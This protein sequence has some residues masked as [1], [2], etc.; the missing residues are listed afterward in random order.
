[1]IILSFYLYWSHVPDG[2]SNHERIT[3][4][5]V[6]GKNK[7]TY[8]KRRN[9]MIKPESWIGAPGTEAP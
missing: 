5:V 2:H 9:N 8:L 1:M 3:N 7:R 4:P 6:F